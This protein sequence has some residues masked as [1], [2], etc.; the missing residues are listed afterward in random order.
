MTCPIVAAIL[1][2]LGGLKISN[3]LT[4]VTNAKGVPRLKKKTVST[5]GEFVAGPFMYRRCDY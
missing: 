3:T 5:P 1:N 2:K 4:N